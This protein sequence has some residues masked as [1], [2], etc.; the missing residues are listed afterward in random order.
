VNAIK[1]YF[2]KR[3]VRKHGCKHAGGLRS[4]GKDACLRMEAGV[5]LGHVEVGANV[6]I[7]AYTYIRSG[8]EL[9]VVSEIG[10]YCSIGNSVIL[11][12]QKYTHPTDWLSTHPFQYTNNHL[13]Y[14]PRVSP[15]VIGHDV[16]IGHGAT[17]MEGVNVGTG[18]VI[19]TK[20]VVT[21]DVLPYA[22]VAG[23]PARVVGMRFPDDVV[24][25]LLESEWWN[26]DPIEIRALPLDAPLAS[27]Q[28]LERTPATAFTFKSISITRRGFAV[29]R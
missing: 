16:W 25:R 26:R 3:L 10:R 20:S 29:A 9:S 5:S 19:A 15:A 14:T 2:L 11:G 4:L 8:S 28:I 21:N 7:G 22:I 23:V 18:A 17:I 12:Q 13:T 24:K 6:S 1:N 27:L